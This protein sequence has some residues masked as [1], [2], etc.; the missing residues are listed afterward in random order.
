VAFKDTRLTDKKL[1]I[2]IIGAGRIGRVHAETLAFRP[3]EAAPMVIADIN[4]NA[5][6]EVAERCGIP[7]VVQ[8]TQKIFN[9][10]AIDAL[11]GK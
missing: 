11:S 4:A 9:D 5:A 3:P 10:P 8:N 2:G 6:R 7:R 1:R